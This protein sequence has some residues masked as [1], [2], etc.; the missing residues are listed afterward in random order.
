M[1][2][3]HLPTF[4]SSANLLYFPDLVPSFEK[5]NK[6][7][8]FVEY[9]DQNFTNYGT[10]WLGGVDSF[11]THSSDQNLPVG[12]FRR[13][14]RD[15]TGH[16]DKF[17]NYASNGNVVDQ[18]FNGYATGST[19]CSGEFAKFDLVNA[20]WIFSRKL[21][22]DFL[23]KVREGNQTERGKERAKVKVFRFNGILVILIIG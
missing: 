10:D 2:S 4:C 16:K 8:N 7:S 11:K 17:N 23:E 18:G 6:D 1:L 14:S 22:R 19:G 5:H 12:S 3:T 21:E 20:G 15:S 9:A 13:Y